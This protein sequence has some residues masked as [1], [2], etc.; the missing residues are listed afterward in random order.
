[1]KKILYFLLNTSLIKTFRF[2]LKYFGIKGFKPKIYISRNVKF[3]KLKGNIIIQSNIHKCHIGYSTNYIYEKTSLNTSFYNEGTII[4]RGNLCISKGCSIVC[5]KNGILEFGDNVHISQKTQIECHKSISLGDNVVISWDCLIIDS[6]T[7]P[8]YVNNRLINENKEIILR[9]GC[10]I[11]ARCTV[12][13]GTVVGKG[14]ILAAS[15][16]ITKK[17]DC[18]NVV[19]VNNE[20]VKKNIAIDMEKD[21]L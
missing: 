15:S 10:W 2:N 8:I 16:V 12:L 13:K 18:E 4:I 1:M 14:S 20:I 19:I 5:K 21:I 6:D 9:E 3:G 11:C 17:I 7:H